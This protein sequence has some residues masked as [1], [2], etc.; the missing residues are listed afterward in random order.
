MA[1]R[2]SSGAGSL[3]VAIRLSLDD[4]NRDFAT[5]QKTAA[6]QSS[7][8][9]SA[10]G[11]AADKIARRWFGMNAIIQGAEKAVKAFVRTAEDLEKGGRGDEGTAAVTRLTAALDH[12][13]E[14]F[15]RATLSSDAMRLIFSTLASGVE[16]LGD[17]MDY[18]A[19]AAD[20][21]ARGLIG[22][23]GFVQSGLG[24][25]LT[26]TGG[27]ATSIADVLEKLGASETAATMRGA[28]SAAANLGPK[29][30]A[31]GETNRTYASRSHTTPIA[32]PSTD[33]G[34]LDV[35]RGNVDAFVNSWDSGF[36]RL[37]S[38]F[39]KFGADTKN[40]ILGLSQDSA[41]GLGSLFS[42]IAFV[43]PMLQRTFGQSEE[44]ARKFQVAQLAL[45]GAMSVV[46]GAFEFAEGWAALGKKDADGAAGHLAASALYAVAAGLAGVAAFRE[47]GASTRDGG[48]NPGVSGAD[49]FSERRKNVTVVIQNA[50]GGEQ[51]VR[52]EIIPQ[53]RRA[54]GED[55]VILQSSSSGGA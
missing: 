34:F 32:E 41:K 12:L 44:A 17:N 6:G 27:F 15:V 11:D 3:S 4:Y 40:S 35:V 42:S 53:I 1:K 25:I 29:L 20:Y 45:V 50:I 16:F 52:D 14:R 46:K 31:M 18:V 5:A 43:G 22:F 21:A 33:T 9:Q 24:A 13:W 54:S 48:V 39:T 7:S 49:R 36:A 51:F 26:A 8:M 2:P 38:L 55:V 19:E 10:L 30:G 47:A 28:G 23:V 37:G